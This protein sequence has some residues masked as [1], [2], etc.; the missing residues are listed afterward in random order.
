MAMKPVLVF[1][2]CALLVAT[3]ISSLVEATETEENPPAK[4]PTHAPKKPYVYPPK[5]A[6]VHD[7]VPICEEYCKK[8]DKKKPIYNKIRPCMKACTACGKKCE[9]VPVGPNKCNNWDFVIIHGTRFDCP[10]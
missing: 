3:Q 1:F 9:C 8:H 6:P 2:A 4:A 7:Y 5:K 10:V